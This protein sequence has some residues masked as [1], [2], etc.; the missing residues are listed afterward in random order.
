MHY[1]GARGSK[2]VLGQLPS[3]VFDE[4]GRGTCPFHFISF[5]SHCFGLK[6]LLRAQGFPDGTD[7]KGLSARQLGG[8]VGNSWPLPVSAALLK[9]PDFQ[10]PS[11]TPH[12]NDYSA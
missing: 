2:S 12:D 4:Q 11:P 7:V 1:A 5:F 9:A 8:A 6:E 10:I 3:K